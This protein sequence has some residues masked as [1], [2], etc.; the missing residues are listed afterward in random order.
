MIRD[1]RRCLVMRPPLA[2]S[3]VTFGFAPVHV[4]EQVERLDTDLDVLP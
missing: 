3:S 2:L 4:V 1:H